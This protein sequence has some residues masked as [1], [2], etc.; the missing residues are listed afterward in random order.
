M[1]SRPIGVFD[2]GLGGLTVINAMSKTM[3][4]ESF[5]Y[6]GDTARVPYGG[7]NVDTIR[8]YGRQIVNFLQSQD[9]KAI[10]VACGTVSSNVMESLN[11]EFDLPII[12]VVR[13]GIEHCIQ[14]CEENNKKKI[15][16][17]ATETTVKS[18][19]FQKMFKEKN[20]SI[21]I[22]VRACPLFVPLIEE[23]W[24]KNIVLSRIA[25][26]YLRDWQEDPIDFLILGCTHYPL[27]SPILQSILKD[28]VLLDMA[29]AAV[30]TTHQYL[31]ENDILN[32]S[33]TILKDFYVS[34]DLEKFNEMSQ[35]VTGQAIQ[36][37]KVF[38]D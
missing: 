30:E 31:A 20:P 6:V 1:D 15:G 18:G 32:E 2:S 33:P 4:G 7:K 16:V 10:I 29:V 24:V 21:E 19:F 22:D 35:Q 36:A 9:V 27:L 5:I 23:G 8:T 26:A 11:E 34:G 38:W 17:I 3:P 13:P 12:D 14:I 28:T 25:E 37:K